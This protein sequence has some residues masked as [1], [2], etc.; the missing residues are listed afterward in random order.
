MIRV[1]NITNT[2]TVANIKNI[3]NDIIRQPAQKLVPTDFHTDKTNEYETLKAP[4]TPKEINNNV[5]YFRKFDNNSLSNEK[6]SIHYHN[7]TRTSSASLTT[8]YFFGNKLNKKTKKHPITI[9]E[10]LK[11]DFS[12]QYLHEKEARLK[13]L[14]TSYQHH[15]WFFPSYVINTNLLLQI[16]TKKSGYKILFLTN[17]QNY[18]DIF[19]T[20]ITAC[21]KTKIFLPTPFTF[22][23]DNQN[24]KFNH[25]FS[26]LPDS[27]EILIFGSME[28][29]GQVKLKK[30]SFIMRKEFISSTLTHINTISNQRKLQQSTKTDDIFGFIEKSIIKKNNFEFNLKIRI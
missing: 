2:N 18:K 8:K 15:K 14:S 5:T 21:P 24:D 17:N 30:A 1:N 16:P 12:Y 6:K 19:T 11:A 13:K 29:A 4:F 7:I 26:H 23:G 27:D 9:K 22:N 28:K 20:K 25:G 10:E 3:A